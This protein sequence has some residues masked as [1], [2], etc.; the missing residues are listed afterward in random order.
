VW[1]GNRAYSRRP[2]VL[3]ML[4]VLLDGGSRDYSNRV[5]CEGADLLHL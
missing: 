2:V 5:D 3:V 4:I 1:V